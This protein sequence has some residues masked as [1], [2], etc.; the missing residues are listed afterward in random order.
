MEKNNMITKN[1]KLYQINYINRYDLLSYTQQKINDI[2]NRS[3]IIIPNLCNINYTY[4]GSISKQIAEAYPI[5]E[6]SYNVIGKV[7]INQHPGYVQFIE[8]M[9]NKSNKLFVAN[10]I[11]QTGV[12]RKPYQ[13]TIN[14]AYL[15]ES[16]Q[17]I[18]KFV[19]QQKI[20]YN[21]EH[22]NISIHSYKFGIGKHCN[23]DWNFITDLFVD[24]LL[25][26]S[27]IFIFHK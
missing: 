17:Q 8:T 15:V 4:G 2:N 22:F 21:D 13:R 5:V 14:Y 12:A 3:I 26:Y 19:C 23:G 24:I 20:K 9:K 10:M 18:K 1:K 7:F 27:N 16:M 6:E 25:P 11:A